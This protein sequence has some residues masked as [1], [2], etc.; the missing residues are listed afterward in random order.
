MES[1]IIYHIIYHTQ[2]KYGL[3]EKQGTPT[4]AQEVLFRGHVSEN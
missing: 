4:L 3:S 2:V 1:H